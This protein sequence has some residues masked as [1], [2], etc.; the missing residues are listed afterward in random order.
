MAADNYSDVVQALAKQIVDTCMQSMRKNIQGL[1]AGVTINADQIEGEVTNISTN[2]LIVDPA[3]I[4][5][6]NEYVAGLVSSARIDISQIARLDPDTGELY[7]DNVHFGNAQI[8]DLEARFAQI[9]SADIYMAD[10]QTAI[11]DALRANFAQIADAQIQNATISSAQIEDLQAAAASIAQAEIGRADI[12]FA[13]IKDLSAHTAIIEKGMNGKLYVADL[14]VTEANMVSLTVG[15]LIVKGQDGGFYAVSVNENGDIVADK[16]T[17]A[18]GD[19]DDLAVTGD[20]IANGTINGD[21]KI[22]ESSITARTLNVQDIFAE[23]AM[24]LKLIAQNINVDELFANEA[25]INKLN[26]TDIVSNTYL[27]LAL[28]QLYDDTMHEVSIMLSDDAIISTVTG[29]KEF[30]DMVNERTRQTVTVTYCIGDSGTE[31]PDDTADWSETLPE[32]TYGDYLWTKTVTE[33]G[34][35]QPASTVYYVSH[36]SEHP[37]DG[38]VLKISSD[39]GFTFHEPD[40]TITMTAD[41]YAGGVM[42]G[43]ADVNVLG[44][45]QWFKD[46]VRIPNAATDNWH[47]LTIDLATVGEHAVYTAALMG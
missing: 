3:N 11:I 44:G 31:P 17:I 13:Q 12:D 34:N 23:N 42:L 35:G 30:S 46:G 21:T 26:T 5:G 10:I 9:W 6:L 18:S 19:I 29:S 2:N 37:A 28:Q 8:E 22:I 25:F 20:K 7:L 16:K 36:Y 32:A 1:V 38:I 40:G 43:H 27:K 39:T 14:A 45:V 33:Y 47:Q 15:E 41:V 24:V 4:T